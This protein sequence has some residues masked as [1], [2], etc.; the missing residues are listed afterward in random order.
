VHHFATN[1]NSQYTEKMAKIAD[2]YGLKLDGK[3]AGWNM[4]SLPHQGRHPNA[5]H[6]FVLDGMKKADAEAEG[7]VDKFKALF[8]KYVKEPVR[9]N[10]ELLRKSGWE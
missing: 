3:D 5:Y 1:K 2:K 4:E 6:D 8:E 10:P 9:N 7:S